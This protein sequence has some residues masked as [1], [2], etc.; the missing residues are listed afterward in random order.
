MPSISHRLTR[1]HRP[2]IPNQEKFKGKIYH[3]SQ[4]D[5]KH[6]KGKNVVVIGGGASAVEALEFVA[7]E[8]AEH[9]NVLSRSE[10][11]IIPRNPLVDMLL[12]LNVFGSETVFSWIPEGLL[13]IF[14]YRDLYDLSPPPNTKG[15]F[16][17]TPMV[18]DEVLDLVR[19][20]KASWVRGDII[21]YSDDGKS[22]RFRKRDQGVPKGGPGIEVEIP[23]DIVIM[24][25][26]YE[27]PSLGFLPQECFEPPYAPPNWYLQVFPPAHVDV[28]ANNCT[29]VN[30]I[31][32]VGNYHI[33]IYTRFLL[34]YL[35]DPL[36]RPR[37]WWMKRWIDMTRFIKA[38]APGGAFDFFTYGELLYWFLFTIVINPFRWKWAAFVLFG[39]GT[40][41]PMSVVEQEDK[42]RNGMGK[43]EH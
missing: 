43:K 26:G 12:S 37:E 10:K 42:L 15:I 3:S 25:T 11:W 21:G 8:K 41:L 4:L 6:A 23:A 14:F 13:R 9:T 32:T 18:N 20:G 27:R 40:A 19:D 36:A 34:M 22:I 28:C 31:G 39:I 38:R 17:D 30:A 2:G 29:Y 35:V 16:T 1:S 5:G 7:H 24:A 33:G